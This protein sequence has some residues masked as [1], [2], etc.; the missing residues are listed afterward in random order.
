VEAVSLM[1]S[2]ATVLFALSNPHVTCGSIFI[3]DF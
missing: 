1:I 2:E 3:D